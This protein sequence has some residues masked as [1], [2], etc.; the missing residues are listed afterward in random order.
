MK[1]INLQTNDNPV[2]G[3]LHSSESAR[4]YN[5]RRYYPP[6]QLNSLVEQFWLVD[7]QLSNGQRHTQQNLPDPNFHLVFDNGAAKL[8]GPVSK[9][10]AYAMQATGRII[11]VKFNIGALAKWLNA[12]VNAYVDK[13]IAATAVFGPQVTELVALLAKARDDE[14]IVALLHR[15]LLPFDAAPGRQLQQ[16][17][18]VFALI[19]HNSDATTVAMLSQ[20]SGVSLRTLQRNFQQYVGLSPKWLIRKYRLHDALAALEDQRTT[21]AD[22][23]ELLDYTDQS[24]LIRDFKAMLGVTPNVYINQ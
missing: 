1:Y 22:V 2:S 10:Y 3:V 7:W 17:Q 15:F 4:Q 13:E 21:I 12:P 18:Q 6:A 24:H 11:G 19:K 20:L 14:A 23:V 9:M 5:L 8:I 16:T